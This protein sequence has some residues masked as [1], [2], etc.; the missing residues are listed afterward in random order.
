MRLSRY[1]HKLRTEGSGRGR[2]AAAVGLGVFIGCT[3]F[4]GAHL[5]IC[6]AVGWALGLNR[7]KLY[8]AANISNPFLAP[9]IVLG[10]I[11]AGSYLRRGVG[12]PISME[13]VRGLDPWLFAA[14]LL[15]GSLVVGGTLG[16]LGAAAA[17]FVGREPDD[18]ADDELIAEA[19]A[20]YLDVGIAAWE[21]ANGKLRF[22]SVYRDAYRRIGWPTEGRVVDLGCGRGLMLALLAAH[23]RRQ[24]PDAPS[25]VA[26][27]GVEYRPR[28]VRL[29]RR[30]LGGAAVIE[31]ADLSRCALPPCRVAMVF[32][33]LHCLPEGVQEAVLGRLSDSVEPGGTLVIR[34]ADAAGGWRFAAGEACNRTVAILQGRWGRR[35]HFRSA[36]EWIATLE[37]FGFGLD[38][39]PHHHSGL[40]ANVMLVARRNGK[41][42]GDQEPESPRHG[43]R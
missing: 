41:P 9:L 42:A 20:S 8:L 34:E 21:L 17:W 36:Q 22:D 19:A 3:P 5:W 16:L 10:E 7:L 32:D 39:S 4:Y 30:A 40:Y 13:T 37:R 23:G 1:L 15:L 18:A 33:V 14:D 2:Q 29:A 24:A 25:R 38:G 26:L 11:Q 6:L 12:Y 28:M 27:H 35:F 31:E 43:S